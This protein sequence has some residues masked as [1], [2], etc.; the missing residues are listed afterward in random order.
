M[1]ST[2]L[3]ISPGRGENKKYLKPPPIDEGNIFIETHLRLMRNN[4]NKNSMSHPDWFMMGSLCHDKGNIT[5]KTGEGNNLLYTAN[6]QGQ[7]VN[8]SLLARVCCGPKIDMH[9][10]YLS[11]WC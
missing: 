6:S 10:T 5:K 4:G 1:V 7:L 9:T 8:C 3:I 2:H 11:S